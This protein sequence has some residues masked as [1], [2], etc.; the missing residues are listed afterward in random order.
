M[1]NPIQPKP[2]DFEKLKKD[3]Q[4]YMTEVKGSVQ[5]IIAAGVQ[6][7]KAKL[8]T[9]DNVQGDQPF[10]RK[11]M[12]NTH[13]LSNLSIEPGSYT[14]FSNGS[15]VE[16]DYEGIDLDSVVYTIRM[17]KNI[18]KTT[19]QGFNGTFK[20]YVSDGDYEVSVSGILASNQN[21]VYPEED[22]NKLAKIL[23]APEQIQVNSKLL[24]LFEIDT[25]VITGYDLNPE[26]GMYNMLPFGF[27]ALSDR[28][29]ILDL[30]ETTEL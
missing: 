9:F 16:I 2:F 18:V 21:G 25:I 3:T 12:L 14:I 26:R 5:P 29:I 1:E 30:D 24:D 17:S 20:E 13:I 15:S 22:V 4:P 6:L 11:S 28:D 10:D 27:S 8:F 7:V 19:M 23:K